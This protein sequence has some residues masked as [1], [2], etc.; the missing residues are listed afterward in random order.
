[1]CATE[2]CKWVAMAVRGACSG[3]VLVEKKKSYKCRRDLEGF[4]SWFLSWLGQDVCTAP[5]L[6][7]A[8]FVEEKALCWSGEEGPGG[9]AWE[10]GR[11]FAFW[12]GF[13]C[14]RNLW[15]R[16]NSFWL[17]VSFSL[18][19]CHRG[20]GLLSWPVMSSCVLYCSSELIWLLQVQSL[21]RPQDRERKEE[22]GG[23]LWGCV[24][25]VLSVQSCS[26][27]SAPAECFH[28]WCGAQTLPK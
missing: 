15:P 28:L 17:I 18:F 21:L 14:A 5:C 22:E 16:S 9:E 24:C 7:S 25:G 6:L 27:A 2:F 8:V 10:G 26:E 19:V 13:F 4:F 3:W 23:F 20:V 1:M 12:V 11:G